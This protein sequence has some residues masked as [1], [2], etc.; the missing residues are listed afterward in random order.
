[1]FSGLIIRPF[2]LEGWIKVKLE[3][4]VSIQVT[5]TSEG[6]DIVCED[7]AGVTIPLDPRTFT[8]HYNFESNRKR[9]EVNLDARRDTLR[10]SHCATR[11]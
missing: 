5:R 7:S 8:A 1:M 3:P 11:G 10:I 9:Y 4:G 6:I 2:I